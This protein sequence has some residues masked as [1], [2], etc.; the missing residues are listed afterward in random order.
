MCACTDL[1]EPWAGNRPGPPGKTRKPVRPAKEQAKEP[2]GQKDAGTEKCGQTGSETIF[3]S[4]MFL[5]VL[6][7]FGEGGLWLLRRWT[8]DYTDT[9]DVEP[10]LSF[11]IRAIRA[12]RFFSCFPLFPVSLPQVLL[13][14]A[15][16]FGGGRLPESRARAP[17]RERSRR[18]RHPTAMRLP[19]QIKFWPPPRRF[20]RGISCGRELPQMRPRG[21][22]QSGRSDNG[23]RGRGKT[24]KAES[25]R[26]RHDTSE[27]TIDRTT[28][29]A[30]VRAGMRM[31]HARRSGGQRSFPGS[32]RPS[33]R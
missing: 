2:G 3:L 22:M 7:C 14:K 24:R 28:V 5:S 18:N 33:D 11:F 16:R 27:S 26:D 31:D 15:S 13:Q 17:R 25:E 32:R 6:A 30:S 19:F 29:P 21:R 23:P 9:T 20:D 10:V 1:W 12:I 8:T 4:P